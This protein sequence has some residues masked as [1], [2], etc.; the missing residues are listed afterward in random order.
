M[1]RV[2][3]RV[4]AKVNFLSSI[5]FRI[6]GGVGVRL[7]VVFA[8]AAAVAKAWG[9]LPWLSICLLFNYMGLNASAKC[10]KLAK[11]EPIV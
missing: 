4:R 3:S 9:D 8:S 1:V 2:R 7:A 6:N 10:K 5:R 11:D